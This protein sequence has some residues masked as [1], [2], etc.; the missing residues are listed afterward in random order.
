MDGVDEKELMLR[1]IDE[2]G[3]VTNLPLSLDSNSVEV[4][5][6]ALRR[7]PGR[8]LINS[9]TA[10]PEK[11]E[12]LLPLAAKYGAMIVL[13]P[14]SPKGVPADFEEKKQVIHKIYDAALE[15]G[16][17]KDDIICDGLVT[18][19][20]ANPQAACDA[21]DTIKYCRELGFATICGISN[22]SYGMP[23]RS[24]INAAFL[25]LAVENGLTVAIL[26]PSQDL[27]RTNEY[28][29]NLVLGKEEADA[30]YLE[31]A[32]KL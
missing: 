29:M 5:E 22:I 14:L 17:S 31:Y 27:T 19:V 23:G 32:G 4:L 9:V 21:L 13:L 3:F 11:I 15:A 24:D 16:L 26:N 18:A 1:A 12:K 20:M 30:E 25:K 28:A 6:A 2:I 10:E 8:A 7:Y